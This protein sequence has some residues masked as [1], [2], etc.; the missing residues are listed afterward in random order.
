M[1]Y[2]WQT[3]FKGDFEISRYAFYMWIFLFFKLLLMKMDFG[4][5]AHGRINTGKVFP[6]KPSFPAVR[7]SV[8][9]AGS[10]SVVPPPW[11]K[12]TAWVMSRCGRHPRKNA[13]RTAPQNNYEYARNK[14]SNKLCVCVWFAQKR[15]MTKVVILS[16]TNWLNPTN[17][18]STSFFSIPSANYNRIP[19]V[20]TP[21][22]GLRIQSTRMWNPQL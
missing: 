1:S 11:L 8:R 22:F 17:S 15:R 18:T 3:R 13:H 16:R 7:Q 19:G 6:S 5:A 2:N 14:C 4:A 12:P 10:Q 9:Q 21:H 20:T